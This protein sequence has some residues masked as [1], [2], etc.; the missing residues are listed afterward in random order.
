LPVVTAHPSILHREPTSPQ[1]RPLERAY[2]R[3]SVADLPLDLPGGL[4]ARLA[5]ALDQEG[6]IPRALDAL[7]PLGGREVALVDAAGG[8]RARTLATLAAN[9]RLVERESHVVALR[10]SL[11]D[12]DGLEER[13]EVV[14]GTPAATGLPDASVDA[15]VGLWSAFRAPADAEAAEADRILRPGGRLLIV[16][17]YGRD[18]VSRLLG[19]RPEYLDW[20]RR[21]GW[22]LRHGFRLRVVHCFWTFATLDDTRG[23]V[24]EAFPGTASVIAEALKRPRLSYNVAVYHRT[25]GA[26]SG[27]GAEPAR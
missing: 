26:P 5:H 7:G 16:H 25:R 2:T 11:A 18:D 19:D 22:Y 3:S 8:I 1:G 4:A 15:V 6:K 17:D 20:G 23:F 12:L 14:S 24:A 13:V 9:L 27:S 10:S 21:S